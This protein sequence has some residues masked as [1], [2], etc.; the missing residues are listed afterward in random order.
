MKAH[1]KGNSPRPEITKNCWFEDVRTLVERGYDLTAKNPSL[2]KSEK[3]LHP[4][5]LTARILE[6]QHQF[7]ILVKR[8]HKMVSAEEQI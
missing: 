2:T 7:Q 5:E 6:N 4:A 1:L 3:I 8:L